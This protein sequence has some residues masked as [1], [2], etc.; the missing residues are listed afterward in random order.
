MRA[1]YADYV[2][3]IERNEVEVLARWQSKVAYLSPSTARRIKRELARSEAGQE[4]ERLELRGYFIA[5]SLRD[6]TFE[7]IDSEGERY[8]FRSL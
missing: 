5:Y 1:T 8:R 6:A 3:A 2:G 7:L 4:E